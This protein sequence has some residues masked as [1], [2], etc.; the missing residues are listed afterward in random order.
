MGC[1]FTKEELFAQLSKT[2][3]LQGQTLTPAIRITPR[4]QI[5]GLG[6]LGET[7]CAT[8]SATVFNKSKFRSKSLTFE[9]AVGIEA[10]TIF[11]VNF[12]MSKAETM[13]HLAEKLHCDW[14]AYVCKT[15]IG[16]DVVNFEINK[17]GDIESIR[18][19]CAVYQ[20]CLFSKN[21]TFS[22]LSQ[23]ISHMNPKSPD[24]GVGDLG[25][26][27]CVT[28]NAIILDRIKFRNKIIKF[29]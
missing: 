24:C 13:A 20:G 12:D 7:I 29:N 26:V 16:G 5:C 25:E 6:K 8:D 2:T 15:G 3:T 27:V 18:F 4:G 10:I 1:A 11:G 28:D 22:S 23:S 17:L 21:E 14:D 19:D 9:S